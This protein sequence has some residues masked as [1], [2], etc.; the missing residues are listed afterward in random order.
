M[1]GWRGGPV[2]VTVVLRAQGAPAKGGPFLILIG[3]PPP[4]DYRAGAGSG[5]SAGREE[6]ASAGTGGFRWLLD[7]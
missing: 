1:W 6:P 7:A 2:W 3:P 5:G 4:A